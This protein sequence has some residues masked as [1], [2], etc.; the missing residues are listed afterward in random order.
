MCVKHQKDYPIQELS[1][2]I[3]YEC[4]LKCI[5]CSSRA[6]FPAP[7]AEMDF[8]LIK[9]ILIQAKQL[10]VRVISLSGGE[11]FLHTRIHD[12]LSLCRELE[13]EILLYTSGIVFDDEGSL[14]SLDR[15]SLLSLAE[16]HG[17]KITLVFD[18]PSSDKFTSEK[19]SGVEGSTSLLRASIENAVESGIKCEAHIVPML[20]NLPY[21]ERT[22][23]DCFDLGVSRVSFLRLVP[24]GRAGEIYDQL[25]LG[26]DEQLFLQ[27]VLINLSNEYGER[28]RIG[29][30]IDFTNLIDET[31]ETSF[32][33]GGEDAP[34]ITPDGEVHVCPAWKELKKFSAGNVKKER[35]ELI[36]SE[37][38]VFAEFRAASRAPKRLKGVCAACSKLSI[39][40]GG[41]TAQRIILSADSDAC[42]Q[43][44]LCL[45]PDPD[46]PIC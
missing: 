5:F 40:R 19:L 23:R 32:C 41:C 46:C 31:R 35:L 44:L 26:R 28:V 25:K 38:L 37:S 33:R 3:T 20:P 36:W 8:S 42:F 24:Q 45:S 10:G 39:C 1:I 16:M 21:V 7:I 11:P 30:P 4:A 12:V 9:S 43:E 18:F 15:K 27:Q 2:E 34:L 17:E 6:E 29:H 13:F 14:T 22:C